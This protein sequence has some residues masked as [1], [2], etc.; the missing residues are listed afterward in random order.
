MKIIDTDI[1]IDHFHGNRFAREFFESALDSGETLAIS[2]VTL[3]ELLA[4][5]RSNEEDPTEKLLALFFVLD[6]DQPIGRKAAA[7]LRK[8][9]RTHKIELGDAL[10]AA[11]ASFFN[12]E[13]VTRNIKHY[14]MSD[15]KVVVPYE[16]GRN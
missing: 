1:A 2:V 12:T 14:P 6:I 11:T 9:N 10:I 15:I 3:T 13:L 4:G 8:Y 5:M 7:Y 16:R